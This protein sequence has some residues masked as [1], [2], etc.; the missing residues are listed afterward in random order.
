MGIDKTFD[1]AYAKASIAAGQKFPPTGSGV[2]V[3]VKD[4]DKNAIAPVVKGLYD[5]GYHLYATSGTADA[6][7]KAGATCKNIY[8]I[9]EG[10]PNASDAL[11]NGDVMMM[12]VTSTGDEPDVRDGKD[13]R[14][15]ALALSVPLITTVSGAAATVGA[16]QAL[17]QGAIEQVPLQDYFK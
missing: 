10:R 4:G 7:R 6:I 17:Q 16:L 1:L 14:R 5:L 12:I 2:F 15:Q 3:S 8:K 9:N 11:L 13:L